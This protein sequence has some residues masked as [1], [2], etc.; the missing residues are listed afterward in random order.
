MLL[1]IIY[2]HRNYIQFLK[3]KCVNY[4]HH[5]IFESIW[6]HFWAKMRLQC[7]IFIL[8]ILWN[9][10]HPTEQ[11]FYDTPSSPCPQLFQYKYD[12]NNWIGELELPSPQIQHREVVLHITLSLRAATTVSC[13]SKSKSMWKEQCIQYC[14]SVI[15]RSGE[16]S[17]MYN[18]VLWFQCQYWQMIAQKAPRIQV[19]MSRSSLV[20]Q[21]IHVISVL[22]TVKTKFWIKTIQK[23]VEVY[24]LLF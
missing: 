2:L 5:A 16:K 14:Y 21:T 22:M 8:S 3:I 15:N 20:Q 10:F 24:L 1:H 7:I 23:L 17:T 19:D 12:G 4:D 13:N 9:R 11:Q 18:C 6:C